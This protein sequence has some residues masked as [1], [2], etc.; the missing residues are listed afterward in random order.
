MAEPGPARTTAPAGSRRTYGELLRFAVVGG[1]NTLVTLALFVLLQQWLPATVA[2]TLV[3]AAGL[4]YTT[5][6]TASVVFGARLTWSTGAAFVGWYL[7]VYGVGL[8]VVHVLESRWDPSAVVTAVVTVAVTAPLNF[9]GGR[10]LFRAPPAA[11]T[12]PAAAGVTARRRSP[13]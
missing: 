11:G 10:L 3:F 12:D 6:L 7:L 5:V 2:Y 1:S 13:G 9:L 4:A 8:L